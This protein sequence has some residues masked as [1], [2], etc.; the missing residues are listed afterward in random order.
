MYS[1]IFSLIFGILLLST[2]G[3]ALSVS[4]SFTDSSIGV[5]SSTTL[6][7]TINGSDSGVTAEL[8]GT[9][10]SNESLT[11]SPV[12]SDGVSTQYPGTISDTTTT[13]WIIQGNAAGTY[14]LLVT[15]SG[16][17]SST[18]G[19]TTLIVTNPANVILDDYSCNSD[20]SNLSS[21]DSYTVSYTLRNS[22]EE[23][24][25]ITSTPT[26]TYFSVGSRSNID[27]SNQTT[28]T[29][30]E[31]KS[32]AFVFTPSFGT[33]TRTGVISVALTGANDP[34]D[35]SCGNVTL[36][37]VPVTDS[38]GTTNYGIAD[39]EVADEE[40]SSDD[41][42]DGV[43]TTSKT[44]T[45]TTDQF[46]LDLPENV[47]AGELRELKITDLNGLPLKDVNIQITDPKGEIT[48]NLTDVNGQLDYEFLYDGNYA[49]KVYYGGKAY[50]YTVI[51]KPTTAGTEDTNDTGTTGGTTEGKSTWWI[52]VVVVIG[53]IAIIVITD[54]LYTYFGNKPKKGGL[55]RL[56]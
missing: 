8:S 34:D 45:I 54:L 32:L 20:D 44:K 5:G 31:T 28:L 36:Y 25:T 38:G 46:K 18:T 1:K 53:V 17:E 33:T 3:F 51:V 35:I 55:S 49:I 41:E 26:L 14:S 48:Y 47:V 15:V 37:V 50:N 10:I 42:E 52:W 22:G 21:G 30:G 19:N 6:T 56:K 16:D 23:S 4:L 24:A 2:F 12:A 29:A 11:T 13:S 27:T 43:V 39:E 40:V 7:A 9:G